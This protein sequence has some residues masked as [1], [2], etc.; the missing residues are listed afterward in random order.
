MHAEYVLSFHN[1]HGWWSLSGVGAVKPRAIMAARQQS[2]VT[3]VIHIVKVELSKVYLE[4]G[5]NQ[6]IS[7]S[8]ERIPR[9]KATSFF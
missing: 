6:G 8:K 1:L 4:K 2:L 9:P 3:A 7:M 5:K